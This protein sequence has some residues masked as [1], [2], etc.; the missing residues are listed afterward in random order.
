MSRGTS[1]IKQPNATYVDIDDRAGMIRRDLIPRFEE[2]AV[3]KRERAAD[4]LNKIYE[5]STVPCTMVDAIA[6][7]RALLMND[8]T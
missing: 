1:M 4:R 5:L 7:G 8:S 6:D 3:T 2:T